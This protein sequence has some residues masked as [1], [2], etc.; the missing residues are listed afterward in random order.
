ML[1]SRHNKH[2]DRD[3]MAAALQTAFLKVKLLYFGQ[4]F[5]EVCSWGPIN[6][7]LAFIQVK[8]WRRASEKP[9][10]KPMATL[11]Q[12]LNYKHS[13]QGQCEKRVMLVTQGTD[14]VC[15]F[16]IGAIVQATFRVACQ[17]YLNLWHIHRLLDIVSKCAKSTLDP[18]I[19]IQKPQTVC[20]LI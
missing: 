20:S 9:S 7:K 5:F 12:S 6:N 15:P 18:E 11:G 3:R 2:T 10:S 8:A 17:T 4:N 1:I 13:I 16:W 19:C 14:V